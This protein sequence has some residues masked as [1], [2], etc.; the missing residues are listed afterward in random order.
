ML[1]NLEE[2][3]KP[4][5]RLIYSLELVELEILKTYIK[6]NLV[7]NFIRLSKFLAKIPNFFNQKL[8]RSFQIYINHCGFYNQTIKI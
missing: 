8:D 3:N 5:F 6:I 4:F 7:N 1:L 2:N